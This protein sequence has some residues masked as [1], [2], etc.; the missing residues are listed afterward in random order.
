MKIGVER[1]SAR[2]CR[3]GLH[4]LA[5]IYVVISSVFFRIKYMRIPIKYDEAGTF[6]LYVREP[7]YRG[8]SNYSSPNNHILHTLL[9][10]ISIW[11]FGN[12]EWALRLP[13]FIS[14]CLLVYATYWVGRLLACRE[15]G[16]LAAGA[17]ACSS[18]LIEYSVNARGYTL[19][20]LLTMG[21]VGYSIRIIRGDRPINWIAFCALASLGFFT[22]PTMLYAYCGILPWIIA[23]RGMK[24]P[25]F[26]KQ[27]AA[28][29]AL[30]VGMTLFLYTPALLYSGPRAVFH[31]RFVRPLPWYEFLHR[32]RML[33]QVLWS[34]WT[35][36][37]PAVLLV[38]LLVG[39]AIALVWEEELFGM[40]RSLVL[41]L[42][43]AII[44][45]MVVQRSVPFA[46]MLLFLIPIVAIYAGAGFLYAFRRLPSW[47]LSSSVSMAAIMITFWMG[48][49]VG[50]AG[51]VVASEETG[52]L[53]DIQA[54]VSYLNSS[55]T[56]LDTVL[57]PLPADQPFE[58]YIQN[59]LR[60]WEKGKTL[61]H[62]A[63]R[64]FIVL[65]DHH[66]PTPSP[67]E[68]LMTLDRIGR[69]FQAETPPVEVFYSQFTTVYLARAA[70][71][72]PG[73]C[74]AFCFHRK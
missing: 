71:V 45:L 37:V 32:S 12:N 25:L 65:R 33:P 41:Y 48:I 67:E 64:V 35:T 63:Q 56:Q 8:I 68:G 62:S 10:H 61:Q 74:A 66:G 59:G 22:V 13:A 26:L 43:V 52:S 72:E 18:K 57:I 38:M 2:L 50:S 17:V 24:E 60:D 11:L 21:L 27:L 36:A 14:G 34:S 58:Y 39:L 1:M 19:L 23:N 49:G 55:A 73:F 54:I 6:L 9:A 28:N 47:V 40:R 7:I 29:V 30:T 70:S 16:L 3:D 53:Q 42:L 20:C 44:G 31:N 15:A 46:R 5:L 51:T 4:V 69:F